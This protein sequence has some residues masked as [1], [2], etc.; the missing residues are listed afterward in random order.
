MAEK[1]KRQRQFVQE[2]HEKNIKASKA[3]NIPKSKSGTH[4]PFKRRNKPRPREP[5][6]EKVT[7]PSSE[8][9]DTTEN[10][11]TVPEPTGENTVNSE[12]NTSNAMEV[13][14]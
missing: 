13:T 6:P 1:Q 12:A 4:S 5:T 3:G 8:P 14:N 9:Q 10:Q 7:Q 2:R 11:S